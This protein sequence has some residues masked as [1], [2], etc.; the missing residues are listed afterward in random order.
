MNA[1]CQDMRDL[2]AFFIEQVCKRAMCSCEA[3]LPKP[4]DDE[5]SGTAF[6]PALRGGS[7]TAEAGNWHRQD[8]PFPPTWETIRTSGQTDTL[9]LLKTVTDDRT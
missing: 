6:R 4:T 8:T 3:L 5:S 7:G 9:A 2:I 1:L